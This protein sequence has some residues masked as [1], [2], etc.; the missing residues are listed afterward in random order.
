MKLYVF[1]NIKWNE[2]LPISVVWMKIGTKFTV[3]KILAYI[4]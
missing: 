4:N 3:L 2:L 1:L